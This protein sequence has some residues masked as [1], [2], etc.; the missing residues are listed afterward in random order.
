MKLTKRSRYDAKLDDAMKLTGKR[1]N[2]KTDEEKTDAYEKS[3]KTEKT[4]A[5]EKSEDSGVQDSDAYEKSEKTDAYEKGAKRSGN[6]LHLPR[7]VTMPSVP[8]SQQTRF[9]DADDGAMEED[10]GAGVQDSWTPEK[11]DKSDPYDAK[12][13]AEDDVKYDDAEDEPNTDNADEYEY[14]AN[15]D[16]AEGEP[17]TDN[18]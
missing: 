13:H 12:D 15:S 10:S 4:D 11:S 3:E 5:Y 6:T 2:L 14:D 16:D 8:S 7:T 18:V 1:S 9:H 17:N